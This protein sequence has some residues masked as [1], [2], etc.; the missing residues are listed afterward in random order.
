MAYDNGATA[1]MQKIE[2]PMAAALARACGSPSVGELEERL[3]VAK[4]AVRVT[5]DD[6]FAATD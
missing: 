1:S 4:T 2:P 6:V 5:F 3:Q